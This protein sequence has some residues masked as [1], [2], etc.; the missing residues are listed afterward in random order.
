ML[1][2][3]LFRS[4]RELLLVVEHEIFGQPKER[5]LNLTLRD[6]FKRDYKL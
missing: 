3:I 4:R 5:K 2:H 1:S 6:F